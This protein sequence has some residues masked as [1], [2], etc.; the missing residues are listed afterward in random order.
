MEEG[1]WVR[2]SIFVINALFYAAF[3]VAGVVLVRAVL[4][5]G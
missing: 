4:G 3:I 5:E 2:L 1:F